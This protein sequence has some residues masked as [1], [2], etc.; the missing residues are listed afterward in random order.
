MY[1]VSGKVKYKDGSIPTGGLCLVSFVP[2]KDSKAEVRR[3]ATGA[4]GADGSFTMFTRTNNDGVYAGEYKVLFNIS[5]SPMNFV[6]L[7]SPKY[8]DVGSPPYT[9]VI[10][11]NK[12]DLD[13]TVEPPSGA[14]T[15]AAPGGGSAPAAN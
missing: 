6:S 12:S 3:P 9:V 5:K 10:D 13:F 15:A 1:Q 14:G 7:V 2:T 4:I 8:T 11:G